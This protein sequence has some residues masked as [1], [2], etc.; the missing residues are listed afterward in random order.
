[1]IVA[2]P[3]GDG[4]GRAAELIA[5]TPGLEAE[6]VAGGV[7]RADSVLAALELTGTELVLVHDAARP[8]A[9]PGLF[10]AIVA[11]LEADPGADAVI[12]AA[13][14]ADTIKR[15]DAETGRVAGT[16][17][18]EGLWAAQTP[19]GFRADVLRE[20]QTAAAAAGTLVEATD[21]AR[22]IEA[23]GGAVLIEPA[24]ASNLKVTTPEDLVLAEVL[25]RAIS[26]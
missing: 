4:C 25:L 7:T 8:L 20:A 21:E 24:P 17:P 12:A 23:A 19:Q 1:V 13:P 10:D 16:V 15:A 26:A 18:R 9:P 5:N 6:V 14:L 2:A 22:L 3:A 11:R